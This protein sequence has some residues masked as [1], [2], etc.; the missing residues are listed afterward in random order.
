MLDKCD[1]FSCSADYVALHL[2]L[3]EER[4]PSPYLSC[5]DGKSKSRAMVSNWNCALNPFYQMLKVSK[6]PKFMCDEHK[7]ALYDS[8][9]EVAATWTALNNK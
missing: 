7:L 6:L 4:A 2:D 3:Q 1:R 5:N 8:K 9:M